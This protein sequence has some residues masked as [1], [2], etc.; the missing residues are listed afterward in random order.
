MHYQIQVKTPKKEGTSRRVIKI[1]NII[2]EKE[3]SDLLDHFGFE[4]CQ[5][6]ECYNNPDEFE[7]NGK[8]FKI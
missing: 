3:L 2:T 6:I 4:K 5:I 1:D 8:I 7:K